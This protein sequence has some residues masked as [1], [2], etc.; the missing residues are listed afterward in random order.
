MSLPKVKNKLYSD[1]VKLPKAPV[2]PICTKP[3]VN[4]PTVVPNKPSVCTNKSSVHTKKSTTTLHTKC[5]RRF[6]NPTSIQLF[7]R[8]TPLQNT[9]HD[10]MQSVKV[11]DSAS[12]KER[13]C[14]VVT[15]KPKVNDNR[16]R[17]TKKVSIDSKS[18]LMA[19]PSKYDL[20]L[21]SM[22][23]RREKLENAKHLP[24]HRHIFDQ[25]K[26]K[27]VFLPVSAFPAPINDNS[28][29]QNIDLITAH[30]LLRKDGRPNYKGLQTPVKSALNPEKFALYLK[31]Y[32][33]WQIPFFVKFGFPLDVDREIPIHSDKINHKSALDHPTHVEKYL[34]DEIAHGAIM[35]PFNSPPFPIHIFN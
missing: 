33:D 30:K 17:C 6:R 14:K 19:E 10:S 5:D 7:N 35:G 28:D 25:N 8:F 18:A 1:V 15:V 3:I 22:A 26:G 16:D 34:A 4:I 12:I 24:S 9:D 29:N 13:N 27:F 31:D 2:S 21:L 20:A 23:K 11:L 32:W